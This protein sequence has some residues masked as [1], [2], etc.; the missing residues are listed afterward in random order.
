VDASTWILIIAVAV[1]VAVVAG[2]VAGVVSNRKRQ[3]RSEHLRSRFGAEYDRTFSRAGNR[4]RAER[5]LVAREREHDRLRLRPLSAESTE[6]YR[7]R[8]Q[9]IQTRF[10]DEPDDALDEADRLL[11]AVLGERG[12]PADRGADDAADLAGIDHPDAVEDYR[13][14]RDIRNRNRRDRLSTE[15]LR[16]AVVSYRSLFDELLAD[17]TTRPDEAGRPRPAKG[18]PR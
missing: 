15:E 5:T 11:L 17:G 7:E 2:V 10:V 9:A 6:R 1:I 14:A 16:E 12:Y 4:R 13:V 18:A 3:R 8:W